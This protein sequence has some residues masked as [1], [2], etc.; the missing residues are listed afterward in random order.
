MLLYRYYFGRRWFTDQ[1]LGSF[2]GIDQVVI[3]AMYHGAAVG[4][5]NGHRARYGLI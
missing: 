4:M 1:A 2:Y 3:D 5:V